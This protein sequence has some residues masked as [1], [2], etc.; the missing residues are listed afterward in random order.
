LH[1]RMR[2]EER[3]SALTK[4]S[5]DGGILMA[6]RAALSEGD[7]LGEVTDLV[8]YDVPDGKDA[9]QQVLGR[10]DRFGRRTQ[11]NVHTFVPSGSA[12]SP[13]PESLLLLREAL[14]S[15]PR[16]EEHI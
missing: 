11:L 6:T 2:N 5:G 8:L 12:D 15:P 3:Q 16:P 9:L 13:V 4:F 10:F 1:G 14:G 7:A